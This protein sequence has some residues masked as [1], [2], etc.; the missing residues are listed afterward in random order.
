[1]AGT[2]PEDFRPDFMALVYPHVSMARGLGSER[3]RAAFLGPDYQDSEIDAYSGENRV[4]CDT[5]RTF[6]VHARTDEV[7]PVEHSRRFAAAMRAKGRPVEYL[8]LESG[9]H[10]LGCGKGELWTA[11]LSAFDGWLQR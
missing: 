2:A 10:G 8:E 5:P 7:C 3:M 9:R 1:M 6:L 11:W 4:T